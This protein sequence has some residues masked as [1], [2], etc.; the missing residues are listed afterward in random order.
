MLIIAYTCSAVTVSAPNAGTAGGEV[1]HWGNA[2]CI[3]K[4]SLQSAPVSTLETY[5]N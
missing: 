3:F 5:P 2:F 4:L 1:R